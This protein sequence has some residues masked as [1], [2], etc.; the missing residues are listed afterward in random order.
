MYRIYGSGKKGYE[1][2]ATVK[3]EEAIYNKLDPLVENKEYKKYLII[4]HI[5]NADTPYGIFYNK[6]GYEELKKE[7]ILVKKRTI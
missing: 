3:E 2:I 7:K 6:K 4:E 1:N 5:N